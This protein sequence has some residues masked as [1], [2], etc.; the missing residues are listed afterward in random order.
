MKNTIIFDMDGVLFDTEKISWRAAKRAAAAIGFDMTEAQQA[1]FIGMNMRDYKKKLMDYQICEADAD[2]YIRVFDEQS[3]VIIDTE[4]IPLKPG[5]RESLEYLFSKDYPLA[6]ASSTKRERVEENLR[7]TDFRKYFGVVFGGDNV[8]HSK[9]APDI[10]LSACEAAGVKPEDA[11]AV[12][13]SFNGIR[14][15]HAAGMR[16]I[17]VPDI[18]QPTDEI[19]GMCEFVFRDLF[20]IEKN[21]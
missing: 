10:Y 16:C 17:M 20:E 5:A 3:Q 15:A 11:F 12:E 9:P 21:F 13:D 7:R 8:R 6:L 4:G 18:I 1:S 2:E 14:S 19:R